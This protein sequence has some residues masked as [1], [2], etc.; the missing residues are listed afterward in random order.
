MRPKT[1]ARGGLFL[2]LFFWWI[3]FADDARPISGS[4]A[5]CKPAMERHVQ[6][7]RPQY[8]HLSIHPTRPSLDRNG[9]SM[10]W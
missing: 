6:K 1:E 10:E 8:I 5:V 7:T 4:V 3:R 9:Y 2:C